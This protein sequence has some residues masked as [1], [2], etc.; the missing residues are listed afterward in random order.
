ME[1][2]YR[3]TAATVELAMTKQTAL[4]S[5]LICGTLRYKYRAGC[6][7]QNKMFQVSRGRAMKVAS[8]WDGQKRL[9]RGSAPQDVNQTW[10]F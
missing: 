8:R 3:A 1:H 9:A 2:I 5:N 10:I 6:M 7:G 4:E